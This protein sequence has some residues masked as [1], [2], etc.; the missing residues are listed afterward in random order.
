MR[1]AIGPEDA[2]MGHGVFTPASSHPRA[3]RADHSRIRAVTPPGVRAVG[4]PPVE[5]LRRAYERI[6]RHRTTVSPPC[7]TAEES[8]KQGKCGDPC[9]EGRAPFQ[10]GR[11]DQA[12]RALLWDRTRLFADD[13][14]PRPKSI[15]A[16]FDGVDAIM[17]DG[18]Y[19]QILCD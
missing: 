11:R 9:Q 6:D 16:I 7:G 14:A 1:Y 12:L 15:S 13:L 18:T 17:V 5:A 4:V 8:A 3:V 10:D 2:R 19:P